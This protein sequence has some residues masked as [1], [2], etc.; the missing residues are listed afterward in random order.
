MANVIEQ[1][2][3]EDIEATIEFLRSVDLLDDESVS[4]VRRQFHLDPRHYTVLLAAIADEPI[5]VSR[6]GR[7]LS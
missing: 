7:L 4:T 5:P 3:P 1:R 2:L 6:T